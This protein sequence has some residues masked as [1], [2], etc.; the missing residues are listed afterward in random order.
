MRGFWPASAAIFCAMSTPAFAELFGKSATAISTA[1][2]TALIVHAQ[3][4][5]AQPMALVLNAAKGSD[6]TDPTGRSMQ[7]DVA[8]AHLNL[9]NVYRSQTLTLGRAVPVGK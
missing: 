8:N 5:Q 1:D 6:G 9:D 7:A 2:E 3:E 4:L